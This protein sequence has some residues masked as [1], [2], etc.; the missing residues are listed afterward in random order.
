[1][2]AEHGL[3]PT[4]LSVEGAVLFVQMQDVPFRSQVAAFDHSFNANATAS[5]TVNPLFSCLNVL[6]LSKAS[7]REEYFII[8]NRDDNFRHPCILL[9][10][11]W[12]S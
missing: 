7:E 12:L 4:R 3:N 9:L 10:A 1:V 8:K 2:T 11:V 6:V 5:S